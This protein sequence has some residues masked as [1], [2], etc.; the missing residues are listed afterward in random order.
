[1]DTISKKARSMN[2]AAI[3]S[4]NTIPELIIKRLLHSMRYK[5]MANVGNL[6]GKPD[7]YVK[8]RNTVIF[9]HG[10]FWHQHKKCRYATKPKSNI[11]F[12][13]LKLAL[14]K[15]RDKENIKNLKK[16]GYRTGVIWEC[17]IKKAQKNGFDGLRMKLKG[18]LDNDGN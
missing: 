10:C 6:P 8:S 1:M 4:R 17:D 7:I 15:V 11:R 18:F 14:N 2:M 16:I 12:W 5:Y 9:I 13:K 3:K